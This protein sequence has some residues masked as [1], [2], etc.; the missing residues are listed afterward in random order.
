MGHES[1][2]RR[3]SILHSLRV[4]ILVEVKVSVCE[5]RAPHTNLTED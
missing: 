4:V 5:Q 2:V 1:V 3:A